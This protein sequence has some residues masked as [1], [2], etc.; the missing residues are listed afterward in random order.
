MPTSSR[1]RLAA[2]LIF[3]L[4]VSLSLNWLISSNDIQPKAF[5]GL[6]FSTS[7]QK[8][9]FVSV[10]NRD[11]QF[12]L[13]D[14]QDKLIRELMRRTMSANAHTSTGWVAG[15][16]IGWFTLGTNSANWQGDTI[17]YR[18]GTNEWVFA[19]SASLQRGWDKLF[20]NGAMVDPLEL[21]EVQWRVIINEIK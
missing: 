10:F 8:V 1:I 4:M 18:R 12:P 19:H 17:Y 3:L 6:D 5:T 15:L 20:T 14:E 9:F 16:P 11:I 21:T 13:A 2:L 7:T